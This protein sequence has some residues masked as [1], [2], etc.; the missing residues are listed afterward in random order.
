MS[1]I[2]GQFF[3]QF[4]LTVTYATIVSLLTAFTVTPMMAAYLLNHSKIKRLSDPSNFTG[5]AKFTERFIQWVVRSYKSLLKSFVGKKKKEFA[6]FFVISVSLV[7]SLMLIPLIGGEFMPSSDSGMVSINIDMPTNYDL[8]RTSQVVD[9]IENRIKGIKEVETI[10]TLVGSQ[11]GINKGQN[12]A[13]VSVQLI[14]AGERDFT[15]VEFTGKIRRLLSDIPD[16]VISAQAVNRMGGGGGMAAISLYVM[17]QEQDKVLEIA[18][19]VAEIAERTPGAVN[20]SLSYKPG[21]PELLILPDRIKMADMGVSATQ[22]A[23]ELRTGIEGTVASRYREFGNE[24][25]I[26]IKLADEDKDSPDMVAQ[27]PVATPKGIVP[28]EQ[29]AKIEYGS[30]ASSITRVDRFNTI[31]VSIGNEGKSTQEVLNAVLKQAEQIDLPQGYKINTGGQ[32]KMMTDAFSSMFQ[33]LLLAII[34]TYMLLVAILESFVQPIIIFMTIPLS[35][36]GVMIALLV[37]GNTLNVVTLMSIIMLVGIV[38]NNAILLIDYANVLR[39]E[40]K[41]VNES[42][43]EAFPVKVKPIL[44]STI[45]IV[46]ECCLLL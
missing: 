23:M 24:Y 12:L 11:G 33:A 27:L 19:K 18:T 31:T 17:G 5:I 41:G 39:K 43:I 13:R 37:T 8:T 46:L 21:K 25:D 45:S 40:G 9:E 35:L 42:I 22:L 29:I 7:L 14:S 20:V 28:L 1:G 34:L 38:V 3:K 32:A 10:T 36:V 2:V 15:S 26:K 30:A 4:G 44:M 6:I 16:A